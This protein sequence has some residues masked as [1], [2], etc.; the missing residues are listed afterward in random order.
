MPYNQLL[1]MVSRLE[2]ELQARDVVIACLRNERVKSLLNH[3]R[4]RPEV[5]P[6]DP[7][8]ALF[9]D[10]LAI[11]GN[12]CNRDTSSLAVQAEN[13]ANLIINEQ[14]EILYDMVTRQRQT[15]NRMVHILTESLDNNQRM[16]QELE[17]EKRKHEHDT[18]QGDDITYGLEIERTKLKQELEAERNQKKKLEKDMKKLQETLEFERN[19]E[20][21]M[22]LYLMAERK[23][24]IKQYLEEG[25]RSQDL[26]QILN[27]E[28]QR[29]DTIAKVASF[30]TERKQLKLNSAKDDKRIKELEGE[31]L[32]LR[33]ELDTYRKK[34]QQFQPSTGT[35]PRD[36][37]V[38]MANVAKVV[39]PTATVSSV[40]VSG[41]TTGIA[42]SLSVAPGVQP[43][44]PASAVSRL[45]A[46]QANSGSQSPTVRNPNVSPPPK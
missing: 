12:F 9:R 42:R 11:D 22:V 43:H 36:E 2:G 35:K 15:H 45:N 29:S 33:N 19:R 25:K 5:P 32:L 24:I 31:V 23:A 20:K 1:Q 28:K 46:Q 18:A 14:I 17:E 16:R 27:E 3:I 4:T 21:Q 7:F 40:P 34:L 44:P 6:S 37:G 26:A 8:A 30:D 39:Q 41:P 38:G 13:E 10:K